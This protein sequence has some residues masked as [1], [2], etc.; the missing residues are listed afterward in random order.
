MN[1][2]NAYRKIND[3]K[4]GNYENLSIGKFKVEVNSIT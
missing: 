3:S 2:N 4:I 1:D